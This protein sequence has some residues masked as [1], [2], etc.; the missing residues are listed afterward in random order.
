M[1]DAIF[2]TLKKTLPGIKKNVLLKNHTTFKIGGPAK[3]FLS[4]KEKSQIIKALKLAKKLDLSVFI[5]GGGSNI[6]A[7]DKG[8]DGLV[9][10]IQNKKYPFVIKK[11]NIIEVPAGVMVK[12]L[13]AFSTKNSLQGFEWAGGLPGT[14]GGA[15]RGN[16]GAFG[17]E[18][19][20]SILWVECLDEKFQV[21]KLTNKQCQFSYRSSIFK[22]KNWIV[23]A[24]AIQFKQGDKKELQKIAKA[25]MDYRAS[26][27]PLEFPNA[28]SIFKNYEFE[29]LSEELQQEFAALVKQ[30]P[31]PI[32][33]TVHFILRAEL[34]GIK[35]GGAQVSEK[36]PNFI[37]NIAAATAKDVLDIIAHNQ[38][39]IKEKYNIDIEIEVQYLN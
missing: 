32:I 7:S 2:E 13:V 28:G 6:L 10:K 9:V 34:K 29:K 5:L 12:D 36:H 23:L 33:P 37:V 31:F 19:K 16:A 11:G 17:G 35:I 24:C 20:D 8:F 38:K 15:V 14:V 3:Y 25:N 1:K 4:A 26:R 18:T 39:I 22:E 27:H 30:D 21:H